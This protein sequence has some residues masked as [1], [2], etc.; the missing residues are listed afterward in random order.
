MKIKGNA[1]PGIN[2]QCAGLPLT[3]IF[4]EPLGTVPNAMYDGNQYA[5]KDFGGR[6]GA[7][8]SGRGLEGRAHQAAR[9]SPRSGAEAGIR[10]T[11]TQELW[12]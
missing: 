4:L 8:K 11:S 12:S 7:Y 10:G 3:S 6:G 9:R 2:W 5:K 1:C